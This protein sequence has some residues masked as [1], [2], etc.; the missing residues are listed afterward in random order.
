MLTAIWVRKLSLFATILRLQ[1]VI[2]V[3]NLKLQV[4]TLNFKIITIGKGACN[5]PPTAFCPNCAPEEEKDP[6]KPNEDAERMK[7][8]VYSM[9]NF[10]S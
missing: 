1:S 8:F 5:H 9:I 6:N 3:L 4:F 10:K 2:T 7:R